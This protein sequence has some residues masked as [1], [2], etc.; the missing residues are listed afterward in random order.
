MRLPDLSVETHAKAELVEI[1]GEIRAALR[2]AGVTD[3][4][5]VVYVPHTTAGVTI[6]ENAD[7]D[8]K[9]D[10]LLA[11]ENAVPARPPRGAYR[12][13]EGNSDA[14]V[15]TALVGTSATVI[16]E[17][18]AP[19]LGTWQGIYLCEFDGPRR[20]TVSLKVLPG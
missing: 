4:L 11:L 6:Q 10:F 13:A 9:A 19:V 1:T 15:K 20:R 3:G 12:H 18:G 5:L 7:P 8:V 2:A 14:H 17:R 16:V